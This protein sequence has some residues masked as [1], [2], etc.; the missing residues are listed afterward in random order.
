M[1]LM[2]VDAYWQLCDRWMET[3]F[4]DV[5]LWSMVQMKIQKNDE[6]QRPNLETK[7]WS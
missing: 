5:A 2:A 7:G 1:K 3:C 4:A 6:I